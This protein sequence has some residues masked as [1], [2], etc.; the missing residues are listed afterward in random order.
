MPRVKRGWSLHEM[1]ISLSVMGGVMA[2]SAHLATGQLRFF[3]GIGEVSEVRMRLA[4]SSNVAAS[5]LWSLSP[6]AG[7]IVLALDSA[8]EFR[9]TTATALACQGVAGH[10]VIPAASTDGGNA[11]AAFL[12]LPEPGDEVAAMFDDS[13]GTT[14]LTLRVASPPAAE[15]SCPAFPAVTATWAFSVAEPIDL[16]AGTTLRF[17]RP[18]RL[19][20]YRSSDGRWYLG[21]RDWNG[22]T[23]QFNAIQPVAGPLRP[24]D[25]SGLLTGLRF[26]YRGSDGEELGYPAESTRIAS[27]AI[28]ARAMASHPVRIQGLSGGAATTHSDSVVTVVALRNAP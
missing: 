10:I 1:L 4:H 26:I 19:S 12:D 25:D 2:L 7:D 28:V 9:M 6:S 27:I 15:G 11:L 23:H 22:V 20:L 21:A 8:V 24:Y 5:L 14:W 13:L 17:T 3:R 16:P 18:M